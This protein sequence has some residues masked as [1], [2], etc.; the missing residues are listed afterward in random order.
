M[1]RSSTST[2]PDIQNFRDTVTQGLNVKLKC[3]RQ[4]ITD[5]VVLQTITTLFTY[6]FFL[7]TYMSTFLMVQGGL[8]S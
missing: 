1:V 8:Q 3:F 6:L 7:N 5:T 4:M 2:P